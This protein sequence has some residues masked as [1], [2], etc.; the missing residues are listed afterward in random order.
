MSSIEIN[1]HSDEFMK[2]FD[3]GCE[4]KLEAIG[5]HLE[6]KTKEVQTV[7][8]LDPIMLEYPFIYKGMTIDAYHEEKKYY[9]EHWSEVHAGTYKPLWKQRGEEHERFGL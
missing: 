6:N 9:G 7:E 2:Y 1:D 3:D 5:I 8:Q 4:K